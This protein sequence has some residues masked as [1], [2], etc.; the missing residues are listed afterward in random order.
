MGVDNYE[1]TKIYFNLLPTND[2]CLMNLVTPNHAR[3]ACKNYIDNLI[4]GSAREVVKK[5][6][7]ILL[8]QVE[9][10]ICSPSY[11]ED[12]LKPVEEKISEIAYWN[13]KNLNERADIPLNLFENY[14][15]KE[16]Q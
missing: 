14:D 3:D 7:N 15:M 4:K 5:V 13:S 8:I 9:N 16:Y 11:Y 10:W 1:L 2:Y 12:L 6:S